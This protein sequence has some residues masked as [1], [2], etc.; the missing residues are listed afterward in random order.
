VGGGG[1]ATVGVGVG[2]GRIWG[3]VVGGGGGSG[4]APVPLPLTTLTCVLPSEGTL[5]V[6]MIVAARLPLTSGVKVRLN[7]HCAPGERVVM[8]LVEGV[9]KSCE[10]PPDFAI[11]EMVRFPVPAFVTTTNWEPL[12][13]ATGCEPKFTIVGEKLMPRFVTAV[14]VVT[15]A[16]PLSRT[17][18]GLPVTELCRKS[19]VVERLPLA[20]R[21]ELKRTTTVQDVPGDNGA[22]M[23]QLFGPIAKSLTSPPL[24]SGAVKNVRSAPPVFVNV[25][26]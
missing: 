24:G 7:W 10:S 13:V 16:I 1:A 3:A 9:E 2:V 26:V 20:S 25:T 11:D 23:P 8:Q 5:S 12:V 17:N 15:V 19:R 22:A 14:G 4:A 18:C 21:A 6:T